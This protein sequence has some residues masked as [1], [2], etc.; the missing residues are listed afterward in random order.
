MRR[1]L[2]HLR[3]DRDYSAHER[4]GVVAVLGTLTVVVSISGAVLFGRPA[5]SATSLAVASIVQPQAVLP[6]DGLL[7][8]EATI[9]IVDKKT[10]QPASGVWAGLLVINPTERSPQLTY[11]DWYSF[12]P[13]RAFYQTDAEGRVKFSL[14]SQFPGDIEYAIYVANPELK[15]DNKYQDLGE[16]FTVGFQ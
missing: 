16:R 1:L 8:G 15:N 13:N 9:A 4:W 6:A 3:R 7:H 5:A 11:L 2:H 12:E 10:G 14:G